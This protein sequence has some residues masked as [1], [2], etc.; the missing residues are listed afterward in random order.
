MV[1]SY[2][3]YRVFYY[4]CKYKNFTKAANVLHTSQSSISHSIQTLEHQL[5]CRLFIRSNH[6]IELTPEGEHL[7]EYVSAGCEQFMKGEA[8][9]SNSVN[10]QNGIVYI[11]ANETA[12]HCFLFDALDSFH[13]SY[14]NVKF[15]IYNFSTIDAIHALKN[16]T[17]DLAVV[18]S[19]YDIS[20]PLIEKP[21]KTIHDILIAGKQFSQLKNMS[22]KLTDLAD[23]PVISY[24]QGT[25]TREFWDDVFRSYD[26]ILSPSIETATSDLILPMVKHNLGL[27]FLPE[28][29]AGNA[30]QSKEV[31][32]IPV[33]DEIPARQI[34]M[35]YDSQHPMS[36]TAK[37]FRNFL[38]PKYL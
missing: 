16:G 36:I 37:E 28:T 7:Y 6:G 4:A 27:G 31:F 26:L 24:S 34:S 17:V 25:K 21:L 1:I 29:L 32:K 3:Y 10:H 13:S 18:S 19:P 8:D 20:K 12:L 33:T 38:H 35:I 30:I 9:I 2:D 23:Y 15:K 11:G 5:G 14:P 22:L